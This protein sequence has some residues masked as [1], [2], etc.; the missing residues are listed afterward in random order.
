MF[1]LGWRRFTDGDVEI[2]QRDC[3]ADQTVIR[4]ALQATVKIREPFNDSGLKILIEGAPFRG[5]FGA[6][7]TGEVAVYRKG[8]LKRATVRIYSGAVSFENMVTL[9][10]GLKNVNQG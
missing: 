5:E 8:Y 7:S 2:Y 3:L 1:I 4:D 6:V 9:L 10:R